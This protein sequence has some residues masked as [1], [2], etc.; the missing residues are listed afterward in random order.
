MLSVCYLNIFLKVP[1]LL[2]SIL[3]TDKWYSSTAAQS[4][5]YGQTTSTPSYGQTQSTGTAAG[6]YGQQPQSGYG[7]SA[8]AGGQSYGQQG[9]YGSQGASQGKEIISGVVQ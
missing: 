4:G 9:G 8:P 6:G 7:Q 1:V 5:G 3:K 2:Q